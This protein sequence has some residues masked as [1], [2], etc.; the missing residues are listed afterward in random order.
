MDVIDFLLRLIGAFYVFAAYVAARA[1][2]MSLL[3]DRA[4]AAI[5]LEKPARSDILKGYWLL[6]ASVLVMASG[7]TLLFLLDLAVW[8]FLGSSLG[9][10][11]YLFYLA[12]R[13]FDAADPPDETGRRQTTNAFVIYLVAT[14]F[15]VWAFG[16][17]R[18]LSVS[19]ASW[20][21]LAVPAAM[22]VAL[23]A[24]VL[25]HSG[26]VKADAQHAS[27]AETPLDEEEWESDEPPV[28]PSDA[29]SVKVMTDYDCHPLWLSTKNFESNVSPA[30][31]DLSPEL[32]RDLKQW[33][34]AFDSSLNRENPAE[35]FWSDEEHEAHM[36]LGRPLAV[37]LARE[38]PDLVVYVMDYQ[39]GQIAVH[40]DDSVD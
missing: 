25:K 27:L 7:A 30:E 32:A 3:I 38:R 39:I 20:P 10:A 31:L 28:E 1:S 23:I 36:R 22:V 13:Y 17:G 34:D 33:A 14:A 2:V 26:G 21:A 29:K 19:E 15:V 24:Y 35:S 12:P 5:A 37:R 11:I 4:I 6:A 18:L 16:S 40:A 9:Q 8:A